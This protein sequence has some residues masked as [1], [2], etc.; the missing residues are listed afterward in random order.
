MY[1]V[2]NILTISTY[3][4]IAAHII[5][6]VVFL[7]YSVSVEISTIYFDYIYSKYV[8]NEKLAILK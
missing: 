5:H 8:C 1:N 7:G 4:S 3:Q 6:A 2:M